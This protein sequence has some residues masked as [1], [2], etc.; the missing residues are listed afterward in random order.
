MKILQLYLNS[1]V[2]EDIFKPA[3]E[4]GS[5]CATIGG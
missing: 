1:A 3:K 4:N 2:G 5:L